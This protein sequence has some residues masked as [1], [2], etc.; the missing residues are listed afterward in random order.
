MPIRIVKQK[1][2]NSQD[3]AKRFIKTVKKSGVLLEMRK[4]AYNKREKSRNLLKRSALVRIK[5]R[6]DFE[7]LKK[8]GKI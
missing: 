7:E 1:K 2:E 3:I 6:Q 5:R 4:K 8:M